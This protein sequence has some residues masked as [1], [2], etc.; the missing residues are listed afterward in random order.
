M[1]SNQILQSTLN[2]LKN[3]T[4]TE[5][6][7]L[8][9]EGK[10]IV[11]TE[12]ELVGEISETTL[13]FIAS[14][15]EGMT[16][17]GYNYFKIF[18][19]NVVELVVAAK[20]EGL[21][22]Y[23]IGQLA[24]FQVQGLLI[25]YKERYDKD[26][27][28]KNLLLDN[29]L[30]A[31]IYDRAKKMSI[32]QSTHRMIYLIEATPSED[33]VL[34][35]DLYRS[36]AVHAKD[37]I[38]SLEE[39]TAVLI[40]ELM[41]SETQDIKDIKEAAQRMTDQLIDMLKERLGYPFRVSVGKMVSDLGNISQSYKEAKTALEIGRIF[42]PHRQVIDD[43]SLGIG[44]L[45]YQLP[46]SLCKRFME[47]ILPHVDIN[48]IDDET[49]STVLKFFENNL[50]VSETSRNLYIHRN[51]LV[52]RLDKLQKMTGLDMRSFDDALLFRML[53]MVNS[54]LLMVSSSDILTKIDN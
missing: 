39:T 37:M 8:E 21:E 6:T 18:D 51:T 49:M 52:Y 32:A 35:E 12:P 47:E 45:I 22:S 30:L 15:A 50:N 44:R 41:V 28:V 13:G 40:R 1:I 26:N 31:D 24:A 43:E 29:L 27:F 46:I 3:I 36:L 2:G 7:V 25:A 53:L 17:K 16:F 20:G 14:E 4:K 10:V 54:Y 33:G 34:L 19:N 42:Y 5:L 23:Q 38:T 48:V 9:R 11:S